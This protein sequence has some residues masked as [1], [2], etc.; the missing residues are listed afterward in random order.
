MLKL[1]MQSRFESLMEVLIETIIQIGDYLLYKHITLSE[2]FVFGFGMARAIWYLFFG[3]TSQYDYLLNDWFWIAAF[4]IIS[5]THLIGFFLKTL[6]LRIFAL[7]ANVLIW[8][9]LMVIALYSRTNIPAAP[10]FAILTGLSAI[11]VVRIAREKN[12]AANE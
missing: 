3:V 11:L 5:F 4:L 2:A 8:F 6:N 1:Q 9:V 12:N 7:Y 10:S